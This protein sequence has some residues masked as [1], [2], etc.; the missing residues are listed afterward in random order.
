MRR[1]R[2]RLLPL[3]LAISGAVHAQET[4]PP[5]TWLLC[6]NPQTLPWFVEPAPAA[7]DRDQA[8]SD[9]VGDS[10]DLKKD[11]QTAFTGNV[12]LTHGDQWL[13][14]DR[15]TYTHPSETFVTE[16]PVQY[17]DH[18]V[19]LTADKA[20]GDQKAD[21]VSLDGVT[22]QFNQ[23]LG[24]GTAGRAVMAGEVGELSTAT[25]STCPPDQQQWQFSASRI[26]INNETSTGVATNVTLRLGGI[27]VIWLPVISFPTDNKRRTGVLSPTIGRDDRNGL[28]IKLPVYLNLAPNYDATLT[29]RWLSKRGL[30]LDSEFRYLFPNSHGV[31]QGTYLPNDDVSGDDRSYLS[32]DH[33]TTLNRH[34]YASANLHHV[35]DVD[36][37][38]DFGDSIANTS[39]SLIESQVGIYGR[40]KYW[41]ASLNAQQWQI[42]NALIAP[43]DEP[44]RRLPR[45]QANAHRP[46]THWLEAGLSAEAVRF[47]HGSRD[48]SGNRIDLRPYLR[49]P[50]GGSA[51]YITPELA[52]RYTAYS[53]SDT[54]ADSAGDTSFTRS[55]PIVSVDAGAY[56]ERNFDWGGKGYVQTLEPRLYYL[57]VPYR[58]QD[59]LPLFD[60]AELTYG[61]TSLFRDNRFGGADRQ[62]DANQATLALG[63]RILSSSDGRERLSA[64]IGRITYFDT[65][66]VTL[67]GSLPLSDNGSAWIATTDL[68]L[69]DGWN[70][71]F[72]QQWDPDTRKTDLS[73]VRSQVRFRGGG[74]FNAAYRYRRDL[75]EQTD[76]SFVV[77][78]NRNWSVYGRWN[79]SLRDNQ[80]LEALAGFERR[81]CCVAVRLLGR[82]YIR[83]FNS[84]QNLGLYLE[85]ELTGLGSFGRDTAR[86]LDNAILGYTR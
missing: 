44:Y 47:N 61:W 64:S 25:Y 84:R 15:L 6:A 19:R 71:G 31:F 12:V 8:P 36:Y 35:S 3:C 43:G 48:A 23:Q 41:S 9:V 20:A 53:V 5:P 2:L 59:D 45:L 68:A 58:D 54:L 4:A 40:G 63:T 83:S 17:Q 13:H 75:L 21:T 18:A 11:E 79:Y 34:W 65:P 76:L 74:V 42:A 80:T 33:I 60:T 70:V 66:R 56:F 50:L 26:K 49:F 57:R 69:T 39:I 73:S 28:D 72:T 81:G 27:P 55:L 86:L 51:W 22:Y 16:G 32:L 10:L 30:M 14:T 7:V 67:P 62:A 82:Q 78:V 29:P 24:N 37:F 52:W 1:S 46:F 77:P 85:I 38:A